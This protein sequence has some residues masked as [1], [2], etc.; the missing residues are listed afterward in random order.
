[1]DRAVSAIAT[2][3]LL[4]GRNQLATL[5]NGAGTIGPTMGIASE[6]KDNTFQFKGRSNDN[7]LTCISIGFKW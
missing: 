5:D 3:Y 6:W 4:K 1:M 7:V 2:V